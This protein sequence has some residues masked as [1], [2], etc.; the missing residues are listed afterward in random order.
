MNKL[1]IYFVSHFF[2][3]RFE[4]Q[5]NISC[6]LTYMW[7]LSDFPW[8]SPCYCCTAVFD[9]IADAIATQKNISRQFVFA[10]FAPSREQT[11]RGWS[12]HP[13]TNAPSKNRPSEN[14]N[15]EIH[16]LLGPR[17]DFFPACVI[18]YSICFLNRSAPLSP[19]L[20]FRPCRKTIS[21]WVPFSWC[22]C[23]ILIKFPIYV[24]RISLVFFIRTNDARVKKMRLAYY[25]ILWAL[26]VGCVRAVMLDKS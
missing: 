23:F 21:R 1:F 10:T 12:G 19:E 5:I 18:P 9:R 15:S 11:Q 22:E 17:C 24:I 13:N 20:N 2:W 16:L 14:W 3:F 8:F 25:C 6:C 4:L 7:F 26:A